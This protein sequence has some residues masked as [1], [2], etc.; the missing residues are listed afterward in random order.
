MFKKKR[1]LSI[2]F[3]LLLGF[4]VASFNVPSPT[5][6]DAAQAKQGASSMGEGT[7]HRQWVKKPENPP[8]STK[9]NDVKV[10]ENVEITMRDGVVL[11]GRLFLPQGTSEP[12]PGLILEN[13]YGHID[14]KSADDLSQ[15]MAEHGYPTLHVGLRGSGTS[16]GENNLFNQYGHDGYDLVEWM[17]K[18]P[19]SDGKVGLIGQSLRGISQWLT[20]KELPP[21]L[22]AIS[23]EIACTDCYNTLW[24]PNGM[25]PGPGRVSR[26][27]PEYSS[28]SQHRDF[29]AWW[30]ERTVNSADL[31][32][33]A[34]Q[35][36]AALISGGWNDY[37]TPGN[38][39]AFKEFSDM[40]G[41]SKLVVGPGAHSSVNNLQPYDFKDLQVAWFDHYL[42]GIDNG[43]DKEDSV[44]IYVQGPNEWRYEKA[45]PIPDA[46]KATLYLQD[47]H[48]GSIQ[49]KNDG[50]LSA[51]KPTESNANESYSYSPTD[52]PFLHTLRSN[53]TGMLTIDQ[54][55]FQE[56]NLTWTTGALAAPTEVTGNLKFSFW[57]EANTA[58]TDFVI[59]I[60]DVAPNGTAKQVTAGYLNAPRAKS[61]AFPTP[62]TPGK[63]E[64]YNIEA[65][66]T[67]YVFEKGHRIRLSLSGGTTALPD[68]VGPQ[69][70]G[71]NPNPANVK[72]YQSAQY[73]S[74]LEIPIIGKAYLPTESKK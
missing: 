42:R 10:Q 63:A 72:I 29:D 16:E 49:S 35:G 48:S 17:A 52:G 24:Y 25:L 32:A 1:L 40:G 33:I 11:R 47:Q 9:T 23:P 2:S 19:W 15:Y 8:I 51:K 71:L 5:K 59:E 38:V 60:S 12:N 55:P 50:S 46:R 27:E 57:A 7:Q 54:R 20:A 70:P 26:G 68:Q 39:Q 62:L 14:Q 45:W 4:S 53:K 74:S 3:T 73:P 41:S 31:E 37:I 58:D 64:Q 34:K 13:G 56:K 18:Q 44:L 67:S 66:P 61:Q 69:G 43:I 30:R 6:V 22:Q 36:I 65:M 21:S 28:A